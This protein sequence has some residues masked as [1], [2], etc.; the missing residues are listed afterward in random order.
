MS[1]AF[2]GVVHFLI[3]EHGLGGVGPEGKRNP[4]ARQLVEDGQ[5]VIPSSRG[6]AGSQSANRIRA[7]LLRSASQDFDPCEPVPELA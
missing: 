4:R 1:K 3:E 6:L 5:C 2:E 7:M